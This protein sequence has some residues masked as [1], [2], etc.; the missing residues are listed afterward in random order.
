MDKNNDIRT[1]HIAIYTN[2]EK[3]IH[4]SEA[5]EEGKTIGHSSTVP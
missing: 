5:A 3:T 1:A 4:L 2:I